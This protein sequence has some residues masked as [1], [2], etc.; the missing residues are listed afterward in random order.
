M[1]YYLRKVL[2]ALRIAFL[3]LLTG[4]GIAIIYTGIS[5]LYEALSTTFQI[6]YTSGVS[7][8]T[9]VSPE[10]YDTFEPTIIALV[11]IVAGSIV[12]MIGLFPLLDIILP[13]FR[14]KGAPNPVVVARL[15]SLDD[16]LHSSRMKAAFTVYPETYRRIARAQ[17]EFRK[18]E[19]SDK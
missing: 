2:N 9:L 7:H 11:M 19:S 5:F 14:K 1:R 6:I 8:A 10:A 18:D 3:V 15:Q 13:K 16:R 4:V 12:V 17:A